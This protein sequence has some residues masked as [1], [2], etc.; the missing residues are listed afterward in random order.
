MQIDNYLKNCFTK[1]AIISLYSIFFATQLLAFT[2]D[3]SSHSGTV[4]FF[5]CKHN[6]NASSTIVRGGQ[7]LAPQKIA[8]F[9]LNKRFHPAEWLFEHNLNT[10]TPVD[11]F[12][13]ISSVT[14]FVRQTLPTPPLLFERRRGPPT[15][16]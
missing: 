11:F 13:E 7:H 10:E 1:A 5:Y 12:V 4:S 14:G 2:P 3:T 16:C 15:A 8:G 6:S 9:R